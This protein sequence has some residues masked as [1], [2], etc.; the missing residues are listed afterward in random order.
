MIFSYRKGM[1]KTSVRKLVE[2]LLRSGDIRTGTSVSADPE[3]MQKGSRLHRKIEK[4]QKATYQSEV[5]LKMEWEEEGY[6][7]CLEGRA[8][9][10]D[11]IEYNG[12]RIPLIDEIKCVYRDVNKIEEAETLH[13]A[14]AKCYACMY[15]HLK[16]CSEIAVQ[17][18][19]CNME[20]EELKKIC[21]VYSMEELTEWFDSLLDSYRM[22]ASWYVKARE[23]RNKSIKKIKFPFPF[24]PGQK[25]MTAMIYRA[26]EDK[27]N[28]FMQ[29][30]T[31]VG[32]TMSA[33]F[34]AL[35]KVGE[36][37]AERIFYLT[38]KTIT[39]SV[40]QDAVNLLKKQKL[41][42]SV[43]SITSRERICPNEVMECNPEKC[44]K[45]KGHYDRIHHALYEL[46]ISENTFTRENLLLFAEKYQVCPYELSFEIAAWADFIICDYNYVFDPH[47]N[48]KSLVE[49]GE[50]DVIFLIDE[51]HNLVDR[52]RDMY[53]AVIAKSDFTFP[54]KYFKDKNDRYILNKVNNCATALRKL[55]NSQKE[56]FRGVFPF[57]NVDAVYF[58]LFRLLTAL[59]EYLK[60]NDSFSEREELVNFYFKLSH[61][62]LILE[63]MNA[64]YEIYGEKEKKDFIL[65][66]FCIDPSE[67]LEEYLEKSV[68]SIFFSATFLPVPYFRQLL[69]GN[70][71]DA[72]CIP[73]PFEEKNRL[74]AIA[75]DVTSR[76]TR[77]GEAEYRK[78]VR[79]LEITLEKKP[80]NYIMF[81]PS[82]EMQKA[83]YD[84]ALQ[85]SAYLVSDF[86]LQQSFMDEEEKK[87]FLQTFR[88][89]R[90]KSLVGFCVL[91]SIFSEGIDLVGKSLI[92]VMIIGTGLPG[93]CREREVIRSFFD[94]KNKK[95]YDYA[96][97]YPGM[98]KVLQAAGRV[99]RSAG[100]VGTI[101]LMDD[102][103]LRR[104][105][106]VLLPQ[107]WSTY[108]A[109]SCENYGKVLDKFW[110][111]FQEEK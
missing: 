65:H 54:R 32:K 64:G 55:E 105:N 59:E 13:L 68:S 70:K 19:Y 78:I 8:D 28:I 97:R 3:A 4:N 96:Y 52:A 56:D 24:R 42:V 18:T 83:V 104:E 38:A 84:V 111:G 53:S 77:R 91:G 63:Q 71:I 47:V 67:K 66:L 108:Y 10:I 1:I 80:G 41:S 73:S 12:N 92:G 60:E 39:G 101:L 94:R 69:C 90:K 14:Q 43:V 103:F 61:F 58:P 102:R 31:G 51:A 72:F 62:Y 74:I 36:E 15:G 75:R 46:L 95:G 21:F 85:S 16:D 17:I 2:F 30:P 40:A 86:L 93:V 6:R 107:E 89:E 110:D 87:N 33:V 49:S 50:K 20:T 35:K 98:N 34:P 25:K 99:I 81:F 37:S 106:Q 57:E 79:Y 44:A 26:I 109:V 7:L 27:K 88:K 29:A 45:A 100:D 9:G 76:Y 5:P 23:G 22:W 48:K 82:Y 11:Q